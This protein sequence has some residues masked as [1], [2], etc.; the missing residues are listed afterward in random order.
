MIEAKYESNSLYLIDTC[1]VHDA[2]AYEEV[3]QYFIALL[4]TEKN[5]DLIRKLA[6]PLSLT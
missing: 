2:Y 5:Y 6:L 4:P 3:Y 1:T